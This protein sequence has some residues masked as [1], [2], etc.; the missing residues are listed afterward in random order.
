MDPS[1]RPQAGLRS[2]R[3]RPGQEGS[4]RLAGLVSDQSPE[5][6]QRIFSACM[7]QSGMEKRYFK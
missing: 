6:D 5:E 2:A 3:W 7:R 4:G 1:C